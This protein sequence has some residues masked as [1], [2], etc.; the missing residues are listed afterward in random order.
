ML[1]LLCLLGL[2]L[3]T[4]LPPDDQGVMLTDG[5]C[6]PFW[7]GFNNCCY[8]YV[9]TH[10]P[11][12]DAE[13]NCVS[14]GAHLVSIHSLEENDFVSTLIMNSDPYQ[15]RTWIGLHDVIKEGAGMWTDGSTYKFHHWCPGEPNDQ[16]QN[17][18]CVHTNCDNSKPLKW[19]DSQCSNAYA[20]VC[21]LC[22]GC[23]CGL[24]QS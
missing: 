13:I 24:V 22:S 6:P 2:T 14:Q 15:G 10:L 3:A 5:N 17:E 20:S 1:L 18:D 4:E 16:H 9:G 11:W 7:L 21:K 8:K 12:A 23:P 19:N